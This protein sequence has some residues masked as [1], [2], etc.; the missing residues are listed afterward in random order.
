MAQ[1]ILTVLS[2]VAWQGTHYQLK[3]RSVGLVYTTTPGQTRQQ[4]TDIWGVT[5]WLR[6]GSATTGRW[7]KIEQD[8]R[9]FFAALTMEAGPERERLMAS[10]P[11]PKINQQRKG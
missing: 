6:D 9:N 8:A 7:F 11:V 2:T 4:E 5:W 3:H 1:S 10:L